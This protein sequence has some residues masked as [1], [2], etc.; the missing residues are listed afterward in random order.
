MYTSLGRKKER[1]SLL[2]ISQQAR[3]L[4]GNKLIYREMKTTN[5]VSRSIRKSENF[6]K[7]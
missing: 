4:R 3:L 2:M 6:K 7:Y 5:I 1:I